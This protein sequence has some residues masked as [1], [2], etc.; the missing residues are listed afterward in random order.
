M[1]ARRGPLRRE[2]ALRSMRGRLKGKRKIEKTALARKRETADRE[3]EL[4]S[5]FC[6]L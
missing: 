1:R 4:F 6:L 2:A 3:P 5:G